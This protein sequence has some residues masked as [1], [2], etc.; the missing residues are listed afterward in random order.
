[1][2]D[3][4]LSEVLPRYK[5]SCCGGKVTIISTTSDQSFLVQLDAVCDDDNNPELLRAPKQLAKKA[6]FS[7]TRIVVDGMLWPFDRAAAKA[8]AFA[9]L[10]NLT[11]SPGFFESALQIQLTWEGESRVFTGSKNPFGDRIHTKGKGN[12]KHVC[13]PFSLSI[14]MDI[15][16]NT[17]LSELKL[18]RFCNGRPIS[19]SKSILADAAAGLDWKQLGVK[20]VRQR[21]CSD[22]STGVLHIPICCSSAFTW[23]ICLGVETG[24]NSLQAEE[25]ESQLEAAPMTNMIQKLLT[26][27]VT[28]QASHLVGELT[29]PRKRKPEM[30]K[31]PPVTYIECIAKSLDSIYQDMPPESRSAIVEMTGSESVEMKEWYL[32]ALSETAERSVE[33]P[34]R[35]RRNASTLN[36]DTHATGSEA[37]HGGEG[38]VTAA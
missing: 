24:D 14:Y 20:L 3:K 29:K 25:V 4:M 30:L 32:N 6:P 7:G 13:G 8:G 1:M 10:Q 37:P 38:G 27:F 2:E 11:K 36:I 15:E 19:S 34:P 17:E 12:I 5:S 22:V 9:F 21:E 26:K 23:Q 31:P 28:Q 18:F 16:E 33:P 35:R